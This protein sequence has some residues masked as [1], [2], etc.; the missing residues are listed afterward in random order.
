MLR[1]SFNLLL[2][3]LY[4]QF[5]S[6]AN[7][8]SVGEHYVCG[9]DKILRYSENQQPYF[10]ESADNQSPFSFVINKN[11]VKTGENWFVGSSIPIDYMSEEYL[12][13]R[14]SRDLIKLRKNN[15]RI[16]GYAGT[17]DS[18]IKLF[19]VTCRRL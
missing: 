4:V 15:G 10:T 1:K 3:I 13:V 17:L 8:F 19:Y 14:D 12:H 16:S 7:A 11:S 2:F 5:S 9:F 6:T 18:Y